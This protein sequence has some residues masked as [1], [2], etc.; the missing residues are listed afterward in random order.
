MII[1]TLILQTSRIF[2]LIF[3]Q[4]SSAWLSYIIFLIL[5]GGLLI[6]FIYLSAL[7][8]NEIFSFQ[9]TCLIFFGSLLTPLF[10][11]KK[12]FSIFNTW[13][14]IP[15]KFAQNHRNTLVILILIYILIRLFIV[16][17]CTS[18]LKSPLKQ[19]I[20]EIT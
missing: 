19:K 9:K 5:V 8:P 11:E 17:F 7:I 10:I 13:K 20:Y 14:E 18:S 3:S 4:T 6:I 16:I 1:R 15:L 12:I 2:I